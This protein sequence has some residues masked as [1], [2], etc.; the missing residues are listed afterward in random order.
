M[1]AQAESHMLALVGDGCAVIV[2]SVDA[3]FC[4]E[5]T[6]PIDSCRRTEVDEEGSVELGVL[7]V[8]LTRG[9]W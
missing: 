3:L 6:P 9:G 7:I 5:A 1:A 8:S 2:P 4:L